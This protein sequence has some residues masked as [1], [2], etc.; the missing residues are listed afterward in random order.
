MNLFWF[1]RDLRIEDNAGLYHALKDGATQ[2]M[3]IFDETILSK[4]EDKH[5]PRVDFIHQEITKINEELKEFGSSLKVYHGDPIKIWKELAEENKLKTV[6]FNRDYEPSAIKR[7]QKVYDILKEKKI[8]C[9][10][11]KDQ[12]IFDRREVMK[13]D[14]TP[15]K[16]FTPYSKVW[17]EKLNDFYLKSYPTEKYLSN[18]VKSEDSELP[19]LKDIGFE[20]TDHDFPKREW[21]KSNLKDYKKNRDYPWKDGTSKLS[22][23]LRFGT[24][25]IRELARD[26][27][28]VSETFISELIWRDFYQ[29]VIYH[30]PESEEKAIKEKYRWIEWRN[31][32]GEFEKWCQGKTGYPIVD[33]GMRQL[34]ETGYMHNRVRMVVA[35]FL[36]KHLLIDWKW[37]ERYFAKKL[38]DY[39]LSANVGGWQWAF[40]GGLDAAPYFRIFNP[41]SQQEKFDKDFK[42]I[43]KWVPEYGTAK[44]PE[45]IVNHKEA[46]ERCLE[47][48]KQALN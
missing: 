20:K 26:M 17:L 1:R 3:F 21:N 34:N 36:C 6:F 16:V 4:L 11:F 29:M 19:S 38:L 13:D 46:R 15:Y 28:E 42:Y 25:S 2:C 7:D 44:Y 37:G 18:L 12:V 9:K 27:M 43:K 31:N 8:S 45:P 14:G 33:A 24:I 10:A 39:D 47:V 35:S 40:G 41:T 48:F 32:E 23:H 5:D 22:L 30:F